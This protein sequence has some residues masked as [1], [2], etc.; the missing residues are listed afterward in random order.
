M[1]YKLLKPTVSP[2]PEP[3]DVLLWHSSQTIPPHRQDRDLTWANPK[4]LLGLLAGI[5]HAK[6]VAFD[7]ETEGTFV[8]SRQATKNKAG[9][10]RWCRTVGLALAWDT[11][12]AYLVLDGLPVARVRQVLKLLADLP[13][14]L[15]AH[16]LMFDGSIVLRDLGSWPTNMNTCTFAITKHWAA[17][18]YNGQEW[19]LKYLQGSLL[20]WP[21]TNEGEIDGWL[22]RNGYYGSSQAQDAY[23]ILNKQGEWCTVKPKKGEMWRCPPWVLGEYAKLDAISTLQLYTNVLLPAIDKYGGPKKMVGSYWWFYKQFTSTIKE[24]AQAYLHGFAIDTP[25]LGEYWCDLTQLKSDLST[26]FL[27]HP[28]VAPYVAEYNATKYQS[29]LEKEPKRLNKD[30]T[31]SQAWLNWWERA[32]EIRNKQHFNIGSGDQLQWLFYEKMGMPITKRTASGEPSTDNTMLSTFGEVGKLRMDYGLYKKKLES[33]ADPY[34]REHLIRGRIHPNYMVPQAKTGRLSSKSPNLQQVGKDRRLL[35]LFMPEEGNLFV[36][37]DFAAIE[38]IV[39]AELS[40]DE[41]MLKL[42]GP[43]AKPN[44]PH[45]FTAAGI[46]AFARKV[47]EAGY[48]PDNPTAEGIKRAKEVCYKERTAAKKVNYSIIF[49]IGARKLAEDLSAEGIPTTVEEAKGMIDSWWTLFSGV[50]T[51]RRELQREWKARGGWIR[52]GLGRPIAVDDDFTKDLISRCV[53]STAHDLLTMYIHMLSEFKGIDLDYRLAIP[54]WHDQTMCEVAKGKE[55]AMAKLMEQEVPELLNAILK[56]TITIKMDSAI[57]E[58][59]ADAKGV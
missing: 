4:Q 53:Q 56:G 42:F 55:E 3:D 43:N 37:C 41:N 31:P 49:G 8:P 11:H 57:C 51:W 45:L 22:I 33:F 36:D 30:G 24:C 47:R 5:E 25:K 50:A 58:T 48:D 12:S 18:G 39:L 21:S 40:N 28:E 1:S 13:G 14:E 17:E 27:S 16:N 20:G 38:N 46:N 52:N 59:I 29:A 9:D 35:E 6:L 34:W 19:G 32:Q 26:E 44:D 7:F 23:R 54:D 15:I 10:L 2:K